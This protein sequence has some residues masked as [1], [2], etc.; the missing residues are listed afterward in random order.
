[1]KLTPR[2]K[3]IADFINKEDRVADIG[4]D[5]GYIPVYLIR[6][7]G[8]DRV[9][10]SDINEAPLENA[11]NYVKSA[12]LSD[13]V[14]LR[15]GNGMQ[16]LEKGEADTVIM[17]GMGGILITEIMDFNRELTDSID[18]FVL[19]PMVGRSELAQ[20]LEENFYDISEESLAKEGDKIYQVLKV[21]KSCGE[22]DS[23]EEQLNENAELILKDEELKYEISRA[24]LSSGD[25]HLEEFLEKKAAKLEKIIRSIEK[26]S[27]GDNLEYLERLKSKREKLLGVCN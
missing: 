2:L 1:M 25:P 12:E 18:K 26:N 3:K 21:E 11:E 15:L 27:S 10:A 19:Q 4:T 13:K 8:M 7:K 17:A 20:Y 5:H 22:K 16:V 23:S 24:L 6:E 14:E 9:I